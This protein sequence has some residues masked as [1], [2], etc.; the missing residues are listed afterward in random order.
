[1]ERQQVG[2]TL[3]EKRSSLGL[4]LDD[5]ARATLL[6]RSI[7][8]TLEAGGP[9]EPDGFY[10][11]Y[12]RRYA[13]YLG[14]DG[15]EIVSAFSGMS[16]SVAPVPEAPSGELTQSKRANSHVSAFRRKPRLAS[17]I[18]IVVL[19]LALA[20]ILLW[21]PWEV[22]H[23]GPGDATNPSGTPS[24]PAD[25]VSPSAIPGTPSGEDV[26]PEEPLQK[27]RVLSF[28]ATTQR[29]WLQIRAD[30]AT[31]FSGILRPGES[32]QVTGNYIVVD[33][34]NARYTRVVE[35][36]VDKGVASADKT[37]LT[38]EYGSPVHAP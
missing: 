12:L 25:V 22:P 19:A 15:N 34:G 17:S 26:A 1:M 33:F 30:G 10:K 24:A 27:A 29:A 16:G 8:E 32:T 4:S 31:V 23:T 38:I 20:T 36:G 11:S 14:L 21:R 28:T 3:S 9:A 2:R 18:T 37:V 5:V 35:D 13:E 6:R 7:L